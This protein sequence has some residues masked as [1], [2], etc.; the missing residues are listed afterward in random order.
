VKFRDSGDVGA[1]GF[2]GK[3][4]RGG[5]GVPGGRGDGG[6]ESVGVNVGVAVCEGSTI[7]REGA[8]WGLSDGTIG[9]DASTF[10]CIPTSSTGDSIGAK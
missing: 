7:G 1:I 10:V 6:V 4:G 3:S 2:D 5:G 9:A 8:S